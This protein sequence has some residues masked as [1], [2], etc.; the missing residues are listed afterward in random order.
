MIQEYLQFIQETSNWATDWKKGINF[1]Q[2]NYDEFVSLYLDMPNS[3]MMEKVDGNL[4]ILYYNEKEENLFFQSTGARETRDLPVLEEYRQKFK[5]MGIKSC[6]IAGE[7][8]G[9]KNGTIL[10]LNKTQSVVKTAYKIPAYRNLV[11]HFLFAAIEVNGKSFTPQN[12]FQWVRKFK[13]SKHIHKPKMTIGGLEIFRKMFKEG[14]AKEGIEGVVILDLNG[15]N[16]KV[17]EQN[18]VDLAVIGGGKIGEKAWIKDQ[19]SYL[20]TAFVDRKGN[21]RSSCKVGGGFTFPQRSFFFDYL[22]KNKLY[23]IDGEF[24]VKPKLVIEVKYFRVMM[25]PT[26]TYNFQNGE[27]QNLGMQDSMQ[28]SHPSYMR[29]REDKG[30]NPKDC[31]FEQIPSWGLNMSKNKWITVKNILK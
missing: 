13:V 7:L 22:H 16:Y 18:T 1:K 21:F 31:R 17:K 8:V 14:I 5:S 11:H 20:L 6:K 9:I 25:T 23:E 30:P 15:K 29:L 28:F 24:F 10:P 19:V 3:I 27:Y 2:L 26:I 4:G 12:S